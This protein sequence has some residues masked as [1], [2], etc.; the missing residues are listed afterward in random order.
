MKAQEFLL[1]YT[2]ACTSKFIRV[3]A[4]AFS[5]VAPRCNP[6]KQIS[7]PNLSAGDPGPLS[8]ILL[9]NCSRLTCGWHVDRR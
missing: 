4:A 7:R 5:A 9:T 6:I 8:R 3:P 2:L 1:E